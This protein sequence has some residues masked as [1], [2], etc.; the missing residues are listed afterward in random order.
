[1][2]RRFSAVVQVKTTTVSGHAVLTESGVSVMGRDGAASQ[3]V[4]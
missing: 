2:I 3:T 4:T 1:M